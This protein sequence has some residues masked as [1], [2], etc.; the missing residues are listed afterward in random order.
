MADILVRGI[1]PK[2]VERLK[3]RAR[4]HGRSLQAEAKGILENAIKGDPDAVMAMIRKI[5]KELGSRPMPN[6][7]LT[8]R[9][10]RNR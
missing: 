3:K 2:V 7:T 8:I 6:S 9:K 4:A 5:R 1:E 10:D